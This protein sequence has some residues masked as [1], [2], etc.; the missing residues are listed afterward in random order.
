VALI[1]SFFDGVISDCTTFETAWKGQFRNNWSVSFIVE[2]TTNMALSYA[3][4]EERRLKLL[5]CFYMCSQGHLSF[6]VYHFVVLFLN[7]G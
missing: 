7:C 3:G 6:D 4:R 1:S 5:I 2:Q